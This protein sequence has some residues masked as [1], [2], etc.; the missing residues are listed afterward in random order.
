M[1]DTSKPNSGLFTWREILPRV[2][3]WRCEGEE[4]GSRSVGLNACVQECEAFAGEIGD[5]VADLKAVVGDLAGGDVGVV[6]GGEGVGWVVDV[7]VDWKVVRG[8]GGGGGGGRGSE[9]GGGLKDCFMDLGDLKRHVVELRGD[10]GDVQVLI[11]HLC[12]EE[13]MVD[14]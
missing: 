11:E 1:R 10:V 4:R 9:G 14:E 5:I 2:F 13:R 6:V 12:E 8:G 3:K 7:N